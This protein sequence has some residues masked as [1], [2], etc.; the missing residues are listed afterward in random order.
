[1]N[2]EDLY[3]ELVRRLSL[4][5][6]VEETATGLELR[7]LFGNTFSP[8]LKVNVD[9][10]SLSDCIDAIGSMGQEVFPTS[11]RDV[12]ALQLLL[13]NLE[14]ELA[15]RPPGAAALAVTGRGLRWAD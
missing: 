11:P 8:P 5:G 1:M 7:R 10:S 2:P 6:D 9:G 12:A 15:T 4:D 3:D 13:A 14:E